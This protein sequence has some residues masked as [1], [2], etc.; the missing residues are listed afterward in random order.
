MQLNRHRKKCDKPERSEAKKYVFKVGK[1]ACCS[2]NR[3]FKHQSNANRHFK[4]FKGKENGKV[5]LQCPRCPFEFQSRLARH[6]RYHSEQSSRTCANCKRV[7]KRKD[8]FKSHMVTCIRN[9]E[10]T[11]LFPH[12]QHHLIMLKTKMLLCQLQN[13]QF[14]FQNS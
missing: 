11:N 2:C 8:H 7:F 13:H 5:M 10:M 4:S 14:Q 1:F 9:E 12:L 3:S 6:L